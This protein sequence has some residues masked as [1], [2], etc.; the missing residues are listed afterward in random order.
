M[1]VKLIP[2]GNATTYSFGGGGNNVVAQDSDTKSYTVSLGGGDDFA[3]LGGGNDSVDGGMG[4]D[5]IEGGVGDDYLFAGE[6]LANATGKTAGYVNFLYG[7]AESIV[8]ASQTTYAAGNDT[9]V[10]GVGVARNDLFGDG[11]SFV[12]GNGN[13]TLYAGN[14]VLIAGDGAANNLYGDFMTIPKLEDQG[15]GTVANG[16]DTLISGTGDDTMY[17]DTRLATSGG[18]DYFVFLANSG[19]D[20]IEDFRPGDGDVIDISAYGITNLDSFLQTNVQVGT[21]STEITF[22]A[23]NKITLTGFTGLLDGNSLKIA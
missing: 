6:T 4:S 8:V 11:R 17:G 7:D 10:G 1:P 21:N 2:K 12:M 22:D 23:S 19:N 9:L 15:V 3:H 14:D 13:G 20:V 16:N 18:H 5:S